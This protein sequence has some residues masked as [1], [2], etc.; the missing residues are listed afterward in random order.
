MSKRR[1]TPVTIR[2]MYKNKYMTILPQA[3]LGPVRQLSP[4]SQAEFA[5]G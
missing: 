1:A 5:G 4:L 3:V 2:K